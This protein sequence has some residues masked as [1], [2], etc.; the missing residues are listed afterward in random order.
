M[1]CIGHLTT[2]LYWW[3]P[4]LAIYRTA[5]LGG[6][7]EPKDKDV[8]RDLIWKRAAMTALF[9][10]PQLFMLAPQFVFTSAT[11]VQMIYFALDNGGSV[12]FT[13]L[14]HRIF[15]CCSHGDRLTP[16]FQEYEMDELTISV[17]CARGSRKRLNAFQC[18]RM[19]SSLVV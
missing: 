6:Y 8:V 4:I 14:L 11:H 2:I 5:V 17:A 1:K 16:S 12:W 19:C 10:S 9:F 13:R 15:Q 7:F 3:L 18:Y